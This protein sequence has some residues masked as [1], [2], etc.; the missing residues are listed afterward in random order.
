M[1]QILSWSATPSRRQ[2][3]TDRRLP[4]PYFHKPPITDLVKEKSFFAWKTRGRNLINMGNCC[5]QCFAPAPALN[6]GAQKQINLLGGLRGD[7][8]KLQRSFA[9]LKEDQ[10]RPAMP[11]QTS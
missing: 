1:Y 9:S 5:T 2:T 3:T 6:A 10:V 7:V 11:P 8:A 4:L